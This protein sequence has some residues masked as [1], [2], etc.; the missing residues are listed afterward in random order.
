MRSVRFV[1]PEGLDDP[2]RPSG[3]NR[4]DRRVMD[5]LRDRGWAVTEHPRI[6]TRGR[7]NRQ[8]W[9]REKTGT[10]VVDGLVGI[11]TPEEYGGAVVLLHMPFAEAHPELRDAER[12][13][14]QG[15]AAVVTTSAWARDWVVTHHDLDPARV[16][17]ASPGVDAADLASPSAGGRRLI[18]VG[19]V[20]RLKG[21]AVLLAALE[22][23]ADLD[24]TCTVVG[25][26]HLEPDLVESFRTSAVASRVRLTGAVAAPPYA[27]AD[28]LVAPSLHES[29]G[30][31]VTEARAHGTPVLLTDVG[32]HRE[33][34]GDDQLFVPPDDPAALAG[35][36]RQW[37]TAPEERARLRQAAARRRAALR[38]WSATVD[39]VEPVL[40]TMLATGVNQQAR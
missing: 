29:Y 6:D 33:A 2:A 25:A 18:C 3:G 19:P 1:V 36:L 24:W 37:L 38:P 27:D 35:A 39:A 10:V 7:A 20:T 21:R 5:G 32:G 22:A 17:V 30:M 4:Y 34:A 26:L 23:V 12:A 13:L 9:W 8:K 31:A 15:A 11:E 28:L 40:D 14:V 16:V